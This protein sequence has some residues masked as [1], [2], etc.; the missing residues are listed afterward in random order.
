MVYVV[1]ALPFA[2]WML[3]GY[4]R[5]VPAELEEAAA[6][7]GAGKA[8]TLVSIT[9]P[10][11]APGI[12]ATALFAF[13]SAWNEF[14]FALVLLKTQRVEFDTRQQRLRHTPRLLRRQVR[15]GA[16]RLLVP[17]ADRAAGAQGLRLAGAARAGRRRRARPGVSPQ[18]LSIVEDSPYKEEAAEFIARY[19]AEWLIERLG[20]RTPAAARAAAL[21]A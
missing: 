14:F 8:R 4:V 15:D 6:V 10:L 7:D 21:A 17:A 13:I 18:P 3:V 16:A 9:A 19:N 12:V 11:L 1:W 20:H 5:A 2:L